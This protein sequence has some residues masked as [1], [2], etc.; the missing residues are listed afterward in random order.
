MNDIDD[1]DWGE[2]QSLLDELID[3][4]PEQQARLLAR[5]TRS[6]AI[7]AQVGALL[8]ASRASGILD[9][10]AP[11]IDV[12]GTATGY[13]SLAQGQVV[14]GFTVDRLIGRGGMGEVYLAHRAARD[15]EQRVALKMLR[16][17]A[18]ERGAMFARERQLLAR[19]EHPGIARLIDA[20]IADDGRPFM[21]M[22]FVDGEPID[23]WCRN[24]GADLDTRLNLFRA[25]CDAVAYAH[26][27]LVVHCD[28]KPSNILIDADG[29]VRLLDFGIARLLDET[30]AVP[31]ATQA[32]LTPDYAAPEQ[33]DGEGMSAATDIYAL[34]VLLYELVAGRGP[35]KR[36]GASV[37]AIIRRVLYDDPALPSRIAAEPGAPVPASRVRGDLDA[38]ILKAMRRKPAERYRTVGEIADDVERHQ[39]LSP[40]RARGGSTRYM[41]GRF[42]RRHRW[43]VGAATAI[44][45]ALVIGAGG[46][47][48]QARQTA[49][50]RDTALAE[51]R[52]NEATNQMLT[53]MFRDTAQS[54]A[55]E[56]ATVKQMLDHT[57]DRLVRSVDTSVRSATLVTTLFDL[58]VN[59]EDINGAD[60][61]VTRALARGIGRD[62]AVATAQ[63]QMRAASSAAS[64]GR[65]AEIG[66]LLDAAEPVFRRDPRR[67]E[68]ELVEIDLNRAQLLRRT[69]KLE[70]A[71]ALLERILP[72]A[73]R[74][75]AE[76]HRDL[77]TAYN[78]LLVYMLE[79]GRLDA[80]PAVFARADAAL[81]HTGQVA[82]MQGLGIAQLK[83]VRLLK[84]DRPA[85]AEP[86]FADVVAKRRAR[87]G[88]SAALAVDLLQ[89][90]RAQLARGRY[91]DARRSLAEAET[92]SAEKLTPT[93][94][95]TLMISA[96]LAEAAA[97]AGDPVAAMATLDRIAP[98]ITAMPP[99]PFQPILLRARAIAQFK[100]NRRGEALASLDQ[101][102]RLF[103]ALGPAG[104]SFLQ[105]LPSLRKRIAGGA[106]SGAIS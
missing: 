10:A 90:G 72:V 76:N 27:H 13:R 41:F 73:D 46:I 44:V 80:M 84:L 82:S 36:E 97:E 40:V 33:L 21:A 6:P 26:A 56:D 93:A 100:L 2:V 34:G 7:T 65:N 103:R 104:A 16:A 87:F 29:K 78:N 1:K 38:I 22:E 9:M 95:P 14:G 49:I 60:A 62:D 55:G 5:S 61:L 66:P 85:L 59:L 25:V 79:A 99:G 11:P 8:A 98:T 20:G 91:A 43:A 94:P 70:E 17:E 53:V 15:F 35:W 77:L 69:G 92:M 64:L 30:A 12:P 67:H 57:A 37:P 4:P 39:S 71:I 106:Q 89:L 45:A 75:L 101:A 18:S 83:G 28:I 86:I 23:L 58:Y 32:I 54:A 51:A 3:L 74:V 105:S 102:E 47:A 50:E 31:M 63:L 19:L 81:T 52:R 96:T 88:R 42:L 68:V 48:W 24:R